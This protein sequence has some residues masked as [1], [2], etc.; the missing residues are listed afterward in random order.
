MPITRQSDQHTLDATLYPPCTC[1]HLQYVHMGRWP[2][3]DRCMAKSGKSTYRN[4]QPPCSCRRYVQ[5]VP[6]PIP[7]T[8]YT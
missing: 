5:A 2:G 3:R 7:A 4:V 8:T 1:S 6:G